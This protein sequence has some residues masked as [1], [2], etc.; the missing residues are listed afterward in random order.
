MNVPLSL[1]EQST[2]V[3]EPVSVFPPLLVVAVTFNGH[4]LVVVDGSTVAVSCLPEIVPLKVPDSDV[5]S[6]PDGVTV[7]DHEIVEPLCVSVKAIVLV[8]ESASI[9]V[10]E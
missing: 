2:A 8:P 7:T 3:Y 1:S 10:P 6:L 9:A 5:V 4:P